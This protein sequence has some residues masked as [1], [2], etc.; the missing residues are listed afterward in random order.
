MT[1]STFSICIQNKK[2]M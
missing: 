1:P 2:F